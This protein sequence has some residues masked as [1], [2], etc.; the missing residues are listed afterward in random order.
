MYAKYKERPTNTILI[1]H[2]RKKK[3]ICKLEHNISMDLGFHFHCLS[4]SIKK[5]TLPFYPNLILPTDKF[6]TNAWKLK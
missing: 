2:S 4:N 5:M 1:Y 6:I 3:K